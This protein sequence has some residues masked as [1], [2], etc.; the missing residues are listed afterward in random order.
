MARPDTNT[1]KRIFL[2]LLSPTLLGHKKMRQEFLRPLIR[3]FPNT[4]KA[5]MASKN[6]SIFSSR[7]SNIA[8]PHSSVG[9]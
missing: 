1:W 3:Y 2:L 7:Y 4:G 9:V 5:F 6:F 8:H